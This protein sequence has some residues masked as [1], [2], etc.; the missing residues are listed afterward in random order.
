M[1][2]G[3]HGIGD[4]Y[5]PLMVEQISP[6]SRASI[7]VHQPAK[8]LDLTYA[9]VVKMKAIQ[10]NAHQL[11]Y[12][13]RRLYRHPSCFPGTVPQGVWGWNLGYALVMSNFS[14]EMVIC[15]ASLLSVPVLPVQQKIKYFVG[16]RKPT[17]AFSHMPSI[18]M[19]LRMMQKSIVGV[20]GC[21]WNHSGCPPVLLSWVPHLCFCLSPRFCLCGH[22]PNV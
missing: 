13:L 18:D 6:D 14:L 17:G 5:Q 11:S 20:G 9:A 22:V 15:T 2:A 3:Y 19:D 21:P 16:K 7:V 4:G 12:F 10:Q 8:P 1:N